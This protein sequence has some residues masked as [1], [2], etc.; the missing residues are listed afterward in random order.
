MMHHVNL[1]SLSGSRLSGSRV[2]GELITLIRIEK[3]NAYVRQQRRS[4]EKKEHR[5]YGVVRSNAENKVKPEL[6]YCYTAALCVVTVQ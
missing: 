5:C 3:K 6:L 2:F 4:L 1:S